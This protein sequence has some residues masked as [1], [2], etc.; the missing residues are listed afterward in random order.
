[1]KSGAGRATRPTRLSP[2]LNPGYDAA[3]ARE[4][5]VMSTDNRLKEYDARLARLDSKLQPIA[6]RIIDINQPD[7][8]E[9]LRRAPPALV[10]A[11]EV[12]EGQSLRTS[13]EQLYVST[14]ELRRAIWNLFRPYRSASWGLWP[15]QKPL[16]EELFRSWLLGV[17][18]RGAN[19][20]PRDDIG[21]LW[22]LSRQAA[23]AGVDIEPIL[24][25]VAAI[26]GEYVSSIM[27]RIVE[28]GVSS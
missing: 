15:M 25:S 16:S 10:Q 9:E 12:D 4:K 28:D 22:S 24:K 26:S 19:E 27:L 7:W 11:G 23:S 17:A 18:M 14:P 2:S 3:V 8:E 13:L 20:D 1:V 6:Q 5:S 21:Q